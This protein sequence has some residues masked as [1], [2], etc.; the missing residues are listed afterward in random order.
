MVKFLN[1]FSED[2]KSFDQNQLKRLEDLLESFLY[3]CSDLPKTAFQNTQGRFS[4]MIFESVF[5]ASCAEPYAEN[6]TISGKIDAESLSALKEDPEF[7]RATQ[8]RTSAP[9]NVQ[10]RLSRAIDILV[11]K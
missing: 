9:E 8:S 7:R 4:P 10:T 6:R 1:T 11:L 5:V 2:A 3:S